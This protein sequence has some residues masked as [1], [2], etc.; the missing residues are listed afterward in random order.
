M[1]KTPGR[2]GF[3]AV[4]ALL[5][6]TIAD[7]APR[8][9]RQSAPVVA[10]PADTGLNAL[11]GRR[12]GGADAGPFAAG[13]E[14]DATAFGFPGAAGDRDAGDAANRSTL[15]LGGPD[16][17]AS[18]ALPLAQLGGTDAKAAPDAAKTSVWDFVNKI[19]YGD[20]PEPA[21]WALILIG[22]GMIGGAIRGFVLA[23]RRLA[24]LRAEDSE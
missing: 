20:L 13:G 7:A 2:V 23:G 17:A 8:D 3:M 10:P 16:A 6:A 1:S 12:F 19:R 4:A 9:A 15:D 24:R 21:S 11:D 14:S 5:S 22:F 18:E